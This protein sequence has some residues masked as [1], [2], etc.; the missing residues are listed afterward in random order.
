MSKDD[1][2]KSKEKITKEILV[3]I[4]PKLEF[5]RNIKICFGTTI[6][7][8]FS[9]NSYHHINDDVRSQKKISLTKF[10]LS[11]VKIRIYKKTVLG[12]PRIHE[13]RRNQVNYIKVLAKLRVSK[14]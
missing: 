14:L 4:C 2:R 3:L 13:A 7:S 9:C 10:W 11:S 8:F 5:T 12:H 6:H 1:V